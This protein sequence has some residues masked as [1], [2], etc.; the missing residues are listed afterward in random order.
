MIAYHGKKE[1]EQHQENKE[2]MMDLFSTLSQIQYHGPSAG[3][4]V[5]AFLLMIGAIALWI[6]L[7]VAVWRAMKAHESI[8]DSMRDIAQR[9][10]ERHE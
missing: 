6:L 8:A 4:G 7:I 5:F 9:M 1:A 10:R 3:F 2:A